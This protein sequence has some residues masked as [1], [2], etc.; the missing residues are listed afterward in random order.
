MEALNEVHVLAS[1]FAPQFGHLPGAQVALTTRSG[2]EEYHGSALYASRNEVL[3]A[4]DSFAK[5]NGLGRAPL[6]LNQWGATLGG[7]VR[8]NRTF[9]FSS[10][11]G[12]RLD[13]PFTFTLVVPTLPARAAAPPH[14]QQVLNA[15]PAPGSSLPGGLV[16]ERIAHFSRPSR[17]DAA[18]LRID[19]LSPITSPFSDGTAG[20]RPILS[21][22]LLKL[23]AFDCEAV[24]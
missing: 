5:S 3:E 18:S 15:F 2:T 8:A 10:Y 24:V 16:A 6:R 23:K 13:Q 9:L 1:S 20:R 14:V 21:P 4:N 11:E 12:L 19:L 17:L 22:D 7:P